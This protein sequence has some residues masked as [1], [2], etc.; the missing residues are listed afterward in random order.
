MIIY[1]LPL[2]SVIPL[3]VNFII[4]IFLFPLTYS[5]YCWVLIFTFSCRYLARYTYL[6]NMFNK[7]IHSKRKFLLKFIFLV[8]ILFV[9]TNYNN[10]EIAD[11]TLSSIYI[12]I[13]FIRNTLIL[14]QLET[15]IQL[16]V[17]TSNINTMKLILRNQYW[18]IST[19]KLIQKI[20]TNHLGKFNRIIRTKNWRKFA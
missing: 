1:F 2:S 6:W 14:K 19:K 4:Y 10:Q 5:I 20:N 12:N 8:T 9:A 3:L 7:L 13:L 11:E 16:K 15:L 17:S 18:K